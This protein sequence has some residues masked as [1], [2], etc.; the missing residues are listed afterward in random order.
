ML[1]FHCRENWPARSQEFPCLIQ[2]QRSG[3]TVGIEWLLS[4]FGATSNPQVL[5]TP[6][7]AFA[8]PNM[9]RRT[10]L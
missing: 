5:V 9:N 3:Q 1:P 8:F 2:F 4:Q 10:G 6:G 7:R